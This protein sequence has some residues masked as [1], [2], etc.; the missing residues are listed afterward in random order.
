MP[1]SSS[2]LPTAALIARST[3]QGRLTLFNTELSLR[4]PGFVAPETRT[5]ATRAELAA[6]LV[7]DF[8]LALDAAEIDA[9]DAKLR[10]R[11]QAVE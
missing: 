4:R 5:I 8:G 1:A 2:A 3:P 11:R 6:V 10:D 9:V 7:D